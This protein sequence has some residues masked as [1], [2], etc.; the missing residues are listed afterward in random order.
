MVGAVKGWNTGSFHLGMTCRPDYRLT[1]VVDS[2]EHAAYLCGPAYGAAVPVNPALLSRHECHAFLQPP[3]CFRRRDPH[4]F[5]APCPP[6]RQEVPQ[7][8]TLIDLEVNVQ[9]LQADPAR[10]SAWPGAAS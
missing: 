6:Y 4:A 2:A 9:T 5:L 8:G 7:Y 3:P 10:A 1:E